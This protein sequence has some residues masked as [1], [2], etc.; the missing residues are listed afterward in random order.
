ML[1]SNP[2]RAFL[3][4]AGVTLAI[5]LLESLNVRAAGRSETTAPM[6]MVC[7]GNEFGMYPGAFWPTKAGR[8]YEMPELL[9]PLERH[10][11]QFTLFSHLDHG[12]KGGHFAVHTF[13]TGVNAVDAKTMPDGGIS[14][15]QRAA[16]HVG[17][18]TRFPSLAIGSEGGLHGGPMMSWTRT[19]TRVPPIGGPRQLF[20]K[21]FVDEGEHAKELAQQRIDLRAS[22][23]DTVLDEAQRL[24]RRS[25]QE[26]SQ[27]LEE[28]LESVR[29]VEKQIELDR[30]WQN[31][32]KPHVN[33][34]KPE[35]EGL[36][37]DLP[38]IYQLIK[39]ALQTDSTRI[40]TIEI[41]DGFAA[42][43]LGIK[44]G[45]HNLSHHGQQEAKIKQLVEIERYQT[46]QLAIFLDALT[47]TQD[48]TTGAPMLDSTMV[49][50]GSG[51]GNANSHNNVDL[52][53]LLAGGG[54]RH[55][56][57]RK[58]PEEQNK[59]IPLSN[60]YVSMLQQFGVE[61]NR[62]STSTGTLAELHT[63]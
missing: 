44:D 53:V 46:E 48:A 27:K 42:S 18:R 49:L 22:I 3:K 29:S 62:F 41:G 59:R 14:L 39:L 50:F 5:P 7:V 13:L 6:R 23:L 19:G 24:R 20:E 58:L 11:E 9:R 31:I 40:A 61:T 60:L 63:I 2:R 32:Q 10:R 26:D 37:K 1:P 34:P 15:D 28:Y 45:Y 57:H 54:F 36:T 35:D 38:K 55:G 16:E 30:Q 12:L 33:I 51:M 52:P 21:L 8:K 43:D 25:G 56:E 47:E 4:G 17:S